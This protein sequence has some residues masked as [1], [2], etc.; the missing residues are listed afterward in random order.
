MSMGDY[1][2]ARYRGPGGNNKEM[3]TITFNKQF[4]ELGLSTYLNYSHQTYW[5]RP[6]TIVTT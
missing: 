1:L 3:Y 4:R 2:D 6:P 5:D